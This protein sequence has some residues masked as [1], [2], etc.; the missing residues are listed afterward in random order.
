MNKH[1][2]NIKQIKETA[3]YENCKSQTQGLHDLRGSSSRPWAPE[4][5]ASRS[6]RRAHP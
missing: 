1:E 5:I 3:A 4:K 2:K 6:K